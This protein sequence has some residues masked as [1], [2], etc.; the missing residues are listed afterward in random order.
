MEEIQEDDLILYDVD[1]N[2]I[3]WIEEEIRNKFE[4]IDY[5]LHMG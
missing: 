2:Y 3:N 5:T 4:V 1:D